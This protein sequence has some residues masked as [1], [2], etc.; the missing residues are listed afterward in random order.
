MCAQSCS[1]PGLVLVETGLDPKESG[2]EKMESDLIAIKS[3]LDSKA[4]VGDLTSQPPQAAAA[5]EGTRL[6]PN[7]PVT[8]FAATTA[9]FEITEDEDQHPSFL[10]AS[11]QCPVSAYG[12]KGNKTKRIFHFIFK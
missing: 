12:G 9:S 11:S 8:P 3:R 7:R 4:D 6:I 10:T 5:V 2:R 1:E